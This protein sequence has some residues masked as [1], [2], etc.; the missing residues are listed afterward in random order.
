M[1]YSDIIDPLYQNVSYDKSVDALDFLDVPD[2]ENDDGD[3]EEDQNASQSS[4]D[5]TDNVADSTDFPCGPLPLTVDYVIKAPSSNEDLIFEY[6]NPLESNTVSDLA[7]FTQLFKTDTDAPDLINFSHTTPHQLDTA[8][9]H[10]G[11]S[12]QTTLTQNISEASEEFNFIIKAPEPSTPVPSVSTTSLPST[13]LP[14]E[15]L[16]EEERKARNRRY[17]K[18]SRDR[19]NRQ[20]QDA[21]ITNKELQSQIEALRKENELL[22]SRNSKMNNELRSYKASLEQALHRIEAAGSIAHRTR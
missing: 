18:K 3:M 12:P 15:T 19:K 1:S 9:L 8:D 21:L 6:L 16:T 10:M 13:V 7:D 17:A 11:V 4:G 20:Y 5:V 14:G 2:L 22:R